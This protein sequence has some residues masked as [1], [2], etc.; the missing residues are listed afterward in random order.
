MARCRGGHNVASTPVRG[1][2][3]GAR[4][5]DLRCPTAGN[6]YNPIPDK[7]DSPELI[8]ARALEIGY[9]KAWVADFHAERAAAKA[10]LAREERAFG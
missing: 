8:A 5:S 9:L 4:S 10:F 3:S 6:N 7:D 1:N 2:Y